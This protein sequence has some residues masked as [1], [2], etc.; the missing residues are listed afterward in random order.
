[1]SVQ[2]ICLLGAF[3]ARK[4]RNA[5]NVHLLQHSHSGAER[6]HE[7]CIPETGRW[8]LLET[9]HT[10]DT[11]IITVSQVTGQSRHGNKGSFVHVTAVG[12]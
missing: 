1:M 9:E 12:R 7:F 6:L 8:G 4:S 10:V 5:R 2:P 11:G 3:A